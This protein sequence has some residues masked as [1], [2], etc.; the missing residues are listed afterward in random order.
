M[1]R[2]PVRRHTR[3]GGCATHPNRPSTSAAVR[4]ARFP[5]LQEVGDERLDVLASDRRW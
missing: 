2:C 3:T 4:V 1:T 5:A